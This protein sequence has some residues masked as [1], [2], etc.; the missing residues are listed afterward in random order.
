MN[1]RNK[2]MLVVLLL[3]LSELT[4]HVGGLDERAEVSGH[5]T[6]SE[7]LACRLLLIAD[8][9]SPLVVLTA[10]L[11]LLYLSFINNIFVNI[12]FKSQ[13]I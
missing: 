4:R 12:K 13:N 1:I 11:P 3:I 6:F 5:G 10:L 7:H 9:T 2:G 8:H